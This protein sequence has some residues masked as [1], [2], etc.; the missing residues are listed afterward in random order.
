LVRSQST[1]IF[2]EKNIKAF[3]HGGM[4]KSSLTLI[5][6]MIALS[7]VAILLGSLFAMLWRTIQTQNKIDKVKEV[8][9]PRHRLFLRL[10]QL[11]PEGATC[12]ELKNPPR[13]LLSYTS[14]LDADTNF[15]GRL[16]SLLYI[17]DGRLL[18]ATWAKKEHRIECLLEKATELKLETV[19]EK[20]AYK[21]IVNNIEF[22]VFL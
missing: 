14:L 4:R 21:I 22:P 16:T 1:S 9:I 13:L 17:E 6:I 10:T 2:D 15:R 12:E 5:E 7:L 11:F 3:H 18:L 20:K 8:I 19:I